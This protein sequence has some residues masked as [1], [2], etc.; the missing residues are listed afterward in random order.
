MT[1]LA[2]R[3][4]FVASVALALQA[5]AA[6][7]WA[8]ARTLTIA[9]HY[10]DDQMR[11]LTAC[12]RRYEAENA[13]LRIVHRQSTYADFLQTIL[14]GRLSGNA[15][16]IYNLYSIWGTR[17]AQSRVLAAPPAEILRYVE[18]NYAATTRDAVAVDGKLWGVP[19]EVSVY[20]LVYNKK[21]LSAAGVDR[22]PATL[23][24]WSAA[25]KRVAK[26]G[27]NGALSV[28]GA[29]FG[30]TVANAV[31]PFR[32]QLLSAGYPLF[33]PDGAS[34]NL[35]RPEAVAILDRQGALYREG[36]TSP[37]FE[38]QGF[39]SGTIGMMIMANWVKRSLQQGFGPAFDETVGV[40]PIP[41]GPDWKTY[42]Y[43]FFYGVDANSRNKDDAWRFILWLNTP[44][45]DQASCT[46][47]ML[48]EL[49]ALT[50]HA[51]DRKALAAQFGDVFTKPFA[52]AIES[53]R[54]V[55]E[56]NV[57]SASESERALANAI[58]N[59][60]AGKSPAREA[61]QQADREISE[62]LREKK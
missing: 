58:R 51:G 53:G 10:T 40:A 38:V 43:A 46:G 24:E 2:R 21:L 4:A 37:A 1:V 39:A 55:A 22:P 29:A 34:T 27:G 30:Q 9:T 8:Q 3:A 48:A 61:L 35:T 5:Q 20:M 62:L 52:D 17:L 23:D 56:P 41:A 44:R 36:A 25:A 47:E 7:A 6:P 31:A 16:D 13:G 45:G 54:A 59:V 57:A 28:A 11:P 14:T 60:W 26:P 42:Q 33:G 18:A 49:G 50:G 19:S 32:T 15:P 12:F